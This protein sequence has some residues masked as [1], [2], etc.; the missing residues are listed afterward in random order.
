MPVLRPEEWSLNDIG[1]TS[2]ARQAGGQLPAA[3]Q[4]RLR[5]E[6]G[7]GGSGAGEWGSCL[8]CSRWEIV[9]RLC[10]AELFGAGR[11]AGGGSGIFASFCDCRVFHFFGDDF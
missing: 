1:P 3:G 9:K 7:R 6:G 2:S 5:G 8:R 11:R 10:V 4:C